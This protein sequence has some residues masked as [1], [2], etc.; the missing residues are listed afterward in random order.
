MS[1]LDRHQRPLYLGLDTCIDGQASTSEH[2][3][4]TDAIAARDHERARALMV[5]HIARA[6]ERI[7][8]ALRA[9]GY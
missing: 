2:L 9:A 5:R 1:A 7:V 4:I 8:T 6:E 3:E